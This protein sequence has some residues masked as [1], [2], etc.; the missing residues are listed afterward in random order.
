MDDN[1]GP[2]LEVAKL[3]EQIAQKYQMDAG[4]ALGPLV[5][6]YLDEVD[7]N[8]ASDKFDHA[9][10]LERITVFLEAASFEAADDRRTEFLEA[11]IDG[12]ASRIRS[13]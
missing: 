3:G 9:E 2:Y 12:L 8:L 11:V 7:T 4:L 5:L 10:F 1:H 6:H 13:T